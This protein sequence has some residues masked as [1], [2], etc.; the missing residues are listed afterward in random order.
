MMCA[1]DD[2]ALGKEY[3]NMRTLPAVCQRQRTGHRE[4]RLFIG[5]AQN[6]AKQ[7]VSCR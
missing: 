1:W 5:K 2:S 4:D 3:E 7:H 6:E